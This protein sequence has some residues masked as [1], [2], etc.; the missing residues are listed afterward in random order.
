MVE[1]CWHARLCFLYK[2]GLKNTRRTDILNPFRNK[3]QVKNVVQLLQIVLACTQGSSYG[4]NPMLTNK[5]LLIEIE[6]FL[7]KH[8]MSPSGFGRW[9]VRNP[10]LVFDLQDCAYEIKLKTVYKI[11]EKMEHYSPKKGGKK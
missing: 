2:S 3:G 10:N 9:A 1:F 5:T 11:M 7:A 4:V 6:R 8:N